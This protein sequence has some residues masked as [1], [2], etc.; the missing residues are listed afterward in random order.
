[1]AKKKKGARIGNPVVR[2]AAEA[3]ERKR[4]DESKQKI[5]HL[6]L[7]GMGKQ[8]QGDYS[9]NE[10]LN[11]DALDESENLQEEFMQAYPQW[12]CEDNPEQ[13]WEI[14]AQLIRAFDGYVMW[15]NEMVETGEELE[16]DRCFKVNKVT[17]VAADVREF[18][19]ERG[20][21]HPD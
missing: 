15:R 19:E 14:T 13:P 4:I 12:S 2:A 16:L 11:D 3:A 6:K 1:M 18:L 9:A 17:D 10:L 20:L 8:W 21:I 5:E 7:S